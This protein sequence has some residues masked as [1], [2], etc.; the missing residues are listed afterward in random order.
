MPSRVP[1]AHRALKLQLR[2]WASPSVVTIHGSPTAWSA[3]PVVR[4][5]EF[6]REPLLKALGVLALGEAVNIE[7]DASTAEV[8]TATTV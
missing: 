6:S 3:R 8:M 4:I 5:D 2:S 1:K 7:V